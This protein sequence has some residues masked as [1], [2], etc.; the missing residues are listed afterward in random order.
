MNDT[1]C[2]YHFAPFRSTN[3]NL[4][5]IQRHKLEALRSASA[6]LL[7]TLTSQASGRQA[8]LNA[9]GPDA[10][11]NAIA[12]NLSDAL[13]LP[14][15][16]VASSVTPNGPITV[17]ET[18]LRRRLSLNTS[19]GANAGTATSATATVCAARAAQILDQL[20]DSPAFLVSVTTQE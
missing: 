1:K 2:C 13:Q 4:D 7:A 17:N 14:L 10:L 19:R 8:L 5:Q 12:V 11:L 6:D 3:F 20:C 16:S 18:E 9:F 15:T